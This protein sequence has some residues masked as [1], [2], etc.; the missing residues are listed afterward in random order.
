MV[1]GKAYCYQERNNNKHKR[2]FLGGPG[3]S[4]RLPQ[5]VG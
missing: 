2:L 4:P 1:N 3:A 5:P